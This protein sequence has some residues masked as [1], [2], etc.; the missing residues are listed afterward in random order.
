M[1]DVKGSNAYAKFGTYTI[2][3]SA[4]GFG[5]VI[6]TNVVVEV[7]QAVRTNF[8]L[9]VGQASERVTVTAITPPIA[10]DDE[11]ILLPLVAFYGR[12]MCPLP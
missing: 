1:F 8:E 11:Q 3:T 9:P 5:A 12:E 10:T 2:T 7:N 6:H 4:P